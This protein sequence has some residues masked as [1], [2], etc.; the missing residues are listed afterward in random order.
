MSWRKLRQVDVKSGLA[1]A[2]GLKHGPL[3]F[4]SDA[5]FFVSASDQIKKRDQQCYGKRE[6]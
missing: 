4:C 1:E 5:I 3:S 2:G 6:K